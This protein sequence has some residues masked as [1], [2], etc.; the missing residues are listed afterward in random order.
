MIRERLRGDINDKL[1]AG[2][3]TT[4][5]FLVL[6]LIA[7]ATGRPFIFPSLGPSAYLMA[8]AEVD[9]AEGAYHVIGGHTV[10]VITGMIAYHPIAG[11]HASPDAFGGEAT[12]F[13]PEILL[14]AASATV[15][16]VLCTIT[17]LVL[18]TNHPAACA[19]VLIVALGIMSDPIDGAIIVVLYVFQERIVHPT[20]VRFGFVPEDPRPNAGD[21]S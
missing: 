3:Y 6:G 11:G 18:K 4:L 2:I 15:G 10:A 13:A 1:S 16:M 21:G 9:R 8:T 14:L 20:A 17:M 5:Q 7:W 12:P 19:T